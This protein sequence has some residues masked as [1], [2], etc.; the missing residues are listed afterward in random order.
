MTTM[1]SRAKQGVAVAVVAAGLA[2]VTPAG[3]ALDAYLKIDGIKGESADAQH[4]GE[5]DVLSW[6]WGGVVNASGRTVVNSLVVT[7]LMDASSPKLTAAAAGGSAIKSQEVILTARRD[8]KDPVELFKLDLK[9]ARVVSVKVSGSHGESK[10]TEEITFAFTSA[11][12]TYHPIKIDGTLDTA[13]TVP[14][15]GSAGWDLAG[16]KGS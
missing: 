6:S 15:N 14:M 7:K 13:V 4:K 16:L 1:D 11:T 10:P 5:I 8:L 9:D 2:S 3:A 12:Y